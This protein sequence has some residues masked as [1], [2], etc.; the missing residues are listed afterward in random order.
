M[1]QTEGGPLNWCQLIGVQPPATQAEPQLL[2]DFFIFSNVASRAATI[3]SAHPD[4]E[5]REKSRRSN[6]ERNRTVWGQILLDSF[7]KRVILGSHCDTLVSF[8]EAHVISC[9]MLDVVENVFEDAFVDS[10]TFW[11]IQCVKQRC[12]FQYPQNFFSSDLIAQVR[13]K[14]SEIEPCGPST[15]VS[16]SSAWHPM[17][18]DPKARLDSP[19]WGLQNQ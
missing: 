10:T 1:R 17:P 7:H 8:P 4:Y 16:N 12:R 6:T 5:R 13:Q 14:H 11:Y 18:W 2:G 15:C 19:H 9:Q 3:P